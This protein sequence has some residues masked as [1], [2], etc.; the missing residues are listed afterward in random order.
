MLITM[1]EFL[2]CE[3]LRAGTVFLLWDLQTCGYPKEIL[4]SEHLA[5]EV[6]DWV[7]R[8]ILV[9]SKSI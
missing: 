1:I 4:V 3:V 5:I 7:Q 2:V 9:V 8:F 6:D